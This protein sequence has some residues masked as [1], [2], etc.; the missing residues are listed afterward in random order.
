MRTTRRVRTLAKRLAITLQVARED[1]VLTH[2]TTKQ[3]EIPKGH[4]DTA[5]MKTILV[6]E[7]ACLTCHRVQEKAQ[8]WVRTTE[9][10]NR[11][12]K[13]LQSRRQALSM[14]SKHSKRSSTHSSTRPRSPRNNRKMYL[15]ACLSM[16]LALIHSTFSIMTKDKKAMMINKQQLVIKANQDQKG[17]MIPRSVNSMI[18]KHPLLLSMRN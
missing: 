8:S 4:R 17:R 13:S 14:R 16:R 6:Y 3:Q 1:K 18:C 7:I 2:K 15:S 9:P 11:Y 12:M 10:T 5:R